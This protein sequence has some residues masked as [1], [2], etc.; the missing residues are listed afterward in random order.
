MVEN[1]MHAE[2]EEGI[3]AFLQKRTPSW[4]QR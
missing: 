3:G 1:M 2:S 4:N